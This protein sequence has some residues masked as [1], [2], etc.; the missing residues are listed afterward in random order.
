MSHMQNSLPPARLDD[1]SE[2]YIA[3]AKSR[4]RLWGAE[5]LR[6]LNIIREANGDLL[7]H[8]FAAD[9][10]AY[11]V[12]RHGGRAPAGTGMRR[13][14]EK[15]E[16]VDTDAI[17]SRLQAGHPAGDSIRSVLYAHYVFRLSIRHGARITHKSVRAY[18]DLL[19]TGQ[20]WVAG[21]L[22]ERSVTV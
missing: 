15:P 13:E 22:C 19:E 3:E 2:D 5:E 10:V 4:L 14:A 11:I 8:G 21:M 7:V 1:R 18:R 20:A 12:M 9:T 6:Q 17:V 16:I